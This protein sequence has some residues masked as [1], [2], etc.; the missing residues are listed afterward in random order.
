MLAENHLEDFSISY[1]ASFLFFL[2][3]ALNTLTTLSLN[4]FHSDRELRLKQKV[5]V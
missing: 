5:L 3:S 1:L 4:F 2:Y